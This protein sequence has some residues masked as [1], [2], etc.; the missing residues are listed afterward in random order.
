MNRLWFA[1]VVGVVGMAGSVATAQ[2]ST[3]A[4]PESAPST[5]LPAAPS[6]EFPHPM[7]TEVLYAVP[8]GDEGDADQNGRRSATGDE[9]VELMNPHTK[10][11]TLKGYTL[12]D[13]VVKK[14]AKS[15]GEPQIRFVFPEL[16]LKP[17]EVVVVFNGSDGPPAGPVGDTKAPAARNEKFN[18]AYVF[19]M[20]VKGSFTAFSNE[21]DCVL[22]SDPAGK[23]VECVRWGEESQS[24]EKA[25]PR[26]YDAPESRG[27]VHREGDEFVPHKNLSGDLGGLPFSPGKVEAAGKR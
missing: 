14:G 15:K 13:G 1:A 20:K 24:P 2:E 6:V 8:S 9:F 21:G 5:A 22:L 17:G 26:T 4:K 10:P 27:S 16:T 11:I 12:T 23:P 19:T 18:N 7:I 25:A 3:P